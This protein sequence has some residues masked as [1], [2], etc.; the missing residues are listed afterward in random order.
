MP[1]AGYI[2]GERRRRCLGVG[3]RE[4]VVGK[5]GILIWSK[6]DGGEGG[7]RKGLAVE[8]MSLTKKTG[9]GY[10]Y[11]TMAIRPTF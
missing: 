5:L 11:W 1:I 10:L 8:M 3:V 4:G 2:K 6:M 7:A 9:L